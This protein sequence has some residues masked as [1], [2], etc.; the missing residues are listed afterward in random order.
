[1]FLKMTAEM[2]IFNFLKKENFHKYAAWIEI[3]TK[4]QKK[5]DKFIN[6]KLKFKKK[7]NL[8]TKMNLKKKK[9]KKKWWNFQKKI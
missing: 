7:W 4:M 6:Q 5:G 1:M 3:C 2:Q 9:F 8:K